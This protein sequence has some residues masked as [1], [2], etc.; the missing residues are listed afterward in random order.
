M[1]APKSSSDVPEADERYRLLV[2]SVADYAIYLLDPAGRVASW[3]SGAAKIKQ[4]SASEIIGK[5]FACFYTA[6][7]VA[8]GRPQ[9]N[10]EAAMRLGH[11]RDQGLRVRKDGTTFQ[12]D[13]VITA[14]H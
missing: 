6:E 5:H 2:E 13:V 11:I 1:S 8:A 9:Q 14:L 3:N 12:A 7:D 10:L 4:Y